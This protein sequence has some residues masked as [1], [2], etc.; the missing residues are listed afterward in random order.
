MQ[1]KFPCVV[2]LGDAVDYKQAKVAQGIAEWRPDRCVGQIRTSER[3]VDVGLEDITL[4]DAI[5]RG[6]KTF[7]IGISPYETTLPEAYVNWIVKAIRAGFD[8]ANPLHT[9]LDEILQ[10]L[11]DC[12]DVKI[13]NFRLRTD[14][15]PKGSGERRPGNRLLTVGTDCA[16]GKKYTAMAITK[17]LREL[18]KD[19]ADDFKFCSTGQTGFLLSDG[20]MNNDT[21]AADFLT[22]A[23]EWLTPD[24]SATEWQI[25]EGQGALSHPSFGPGSLGLLYGTQP[26]LLVVCHEPSRKTMRGVSRSVPNPTE[27]AAFNL[28]IAQRHCANSR[29][30]AYSLFT[31]NSTR[32]DIEA[33]VAHITSVDPRAYVF[34]PQVAMSGDKDKFPGL[35]D[36]KAEF[37]HFLWHMMLISGHRKYSNA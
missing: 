31:K 19:S 6:A 30:G 32:E 26:D 4:E 29:V 13:H 27:E 23:A 36:S 10:K 1:I 12:C 33:V 21:I 20:G 17:A 11:A 16:V 18:N 28:S 9:P 8:I 2:F 25:V 35:M 34:D 5:A 24:C 14:N 15:Y 37:Q 3:T 22:G 7:L